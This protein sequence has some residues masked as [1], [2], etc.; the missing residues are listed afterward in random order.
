M[1]RGAAMHASLRAGRPVEV[2][3]QET[4]A[5][6]LAGGIGLANRYS[7][8]MVQQ[9]VDDVVLVSE[10]EIAAAIAAV[11][12]QEQ[13]V[14]EGAAAVGVAALM[15]GRLTIAGKTVLVL[16]GR[17][18]DMGLHHRLTAAPASTNRAREA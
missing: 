16:T 12:L 10:Q 9:F 11:Y 18:I 14:C 1:E 7:F 8:P 3:E 17:N 2:E 15:A 6:C 4:L 5:D 13:I